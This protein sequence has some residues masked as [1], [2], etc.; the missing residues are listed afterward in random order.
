MIRGLGMDRGVGFYYI[1]FALPVS[2]TVKFFSSCILT[3]PKTIK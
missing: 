1:F 3:V 2:E